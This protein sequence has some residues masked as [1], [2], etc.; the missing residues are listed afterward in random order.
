MFLPYLLSLTGF[1]ASNCPSGTSPSLSNPNRCFYFGTQRL[2]YM[3]AEEQCVDRDG[4]LTSTQ[5]V[6]EDIYL[7]QKAGLDFNSS[8][9]SDFWFGA[10]KMSG[11]WGWIDGSEFNFTHWDSSE[12]Q[13]QSENICGA[14]SLAG[15]KW[16]A[17]DCFK[18]HKPNPL[19]YN[20]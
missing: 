6:A 17:Q 12:P 10:N 13:N 19:N 2:P 16:S 11:D 5:S 8:T 20:K 14:L 18:Y 7:S 15:G 1:I 3:T 9:T 4:H